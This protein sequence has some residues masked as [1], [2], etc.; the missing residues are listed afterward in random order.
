MVLDHN[1]E[2]LYIHITPGGRTV[3]G[4]RQRP[5]LCRAVL[6]AHPYVSVPAA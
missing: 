3:D 1:S 4:H 6:E 5:D 2:K